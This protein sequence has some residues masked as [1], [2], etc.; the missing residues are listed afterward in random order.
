MSA[1]KVSATFNAWSMPF[2]TDAGTATPLG[3]TNSAE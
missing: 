2:R 3:T 1:G